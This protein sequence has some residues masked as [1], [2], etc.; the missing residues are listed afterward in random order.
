MMQRVHGY[1]A[2]MIKDTP[3]DTT[4]GVVFPELPGCVS[5]G[6]NVEDATAM[7]H[8]A[9]AGY[10]E[11]SVLD[12]DELPPSLPLEAPLPDWLLE[13]EPMIEV[14]RIMVRVRVDVAAVPA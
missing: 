1:R 3:D 5:A 7:A 13:V 9:L 10:L 4:L 14:A 8:E 12:G 6:D 11:L 2:V